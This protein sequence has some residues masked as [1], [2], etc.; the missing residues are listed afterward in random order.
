MKHSIV[1]IP[2]INRMITQQA[3]LL[4]Y[5]VYKV[6]I[7]Y[8]C[9][10]VVLCIFLTK[11]GSKNAS[12]LENQCVLILIE[13]ENKCERLFFTF[14]QKMFQYFS[15][16]NCQAREGKNIGF[17]IQLT[18]LSK[19]NQSKYGY[20]NTFKICQQK[21]HQKSAYEICDL[22]TKGCEY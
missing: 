22:G 12:V 7:F 18:D 20:K 16:R 15:P 2:G 1:N 4:N 21:R 14:S 19:R 6:T 11:S 8:V 17:P 3:D 13:Y 9:V 10:F 5:V